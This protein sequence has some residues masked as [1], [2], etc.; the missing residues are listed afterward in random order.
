[1]VPLGTMSGTNDIVPKADGLPHRYTL[2]GLI[3]KGMYAP[4]GSG[5]SDT[6]IVTLSFS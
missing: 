3:Q 2:Y 4:V 6:L 5:Y 1:M